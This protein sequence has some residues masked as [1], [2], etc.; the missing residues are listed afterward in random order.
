[1]VCPPSRPSHD[2]DHLS[3]R[4]HLVSLATPPSVSHKTSV[5]FTKDQLLFHL[6]TPTCF[7]CEPSPSSPADPVSVSL[8]PRFGFT[9]EPPSVSLKTS[10]GS[11]CEPPSVSSKTSVVS[12]ANPRWFHLRPPSVSPANHHRF[13]QRPASVPLA[14]PHRFHQRPASVSPAN[15]DLVHLRT[16]YVFLFLGVKTECKIKVA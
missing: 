15:P 8:G 4:S 1:L 5:G 9:N 3:C 6:R 2:P 14:N 16:L 10:F 7:T 12:P 11:T 13:H